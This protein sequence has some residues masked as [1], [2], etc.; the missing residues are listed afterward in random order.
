[1]YNGDTK[2]FNIEQPKDES[3]N[4]IIEIRDGE[5]V[6]TLEDEI[7]NNM[8]YEEPEVEEEQP[9]KKNKN[10]FKV[11]KNKWNDL[12]KKQK[13]IAIAIIAVVLIALIITLI[14]V[15]KK[16]E[17]VIEEPVVLEADNYRYENGKLY[18]LDKD[19]EDI[20]SY[21]CT[22]KKE[23]LCYVAYSSNE[24]NFDIEKNIYKDETDVQKRMSIIN[25]NYVFIYDNKNKNEDNIILYSIKENADYEAFKLVKEYNLEDDYIIAKNE[26][27]YYGVLLF[28]K[29]GYE[30]VIEFKYD[31][32]GVITENK[33][34]NKYLVG[35]K[36]NKWYLIDFKGVEKTKAYDNEIKNYSDSLLSIENA[37]EYYLYDFKG[38]L[39]TDESYDYINFYDEY[40]ILIKEEKL[41]IVDKD[42][43]KLYEEVIKVNMTSEDNYN[44]IN[45]FDKKTNK[46]VETKSSYKLEINNNTI[47]LFIKNGTEEVEKQINTFD[48]LVSKNY[49][50]INYFGG[51]LYFYSDE[52]KTELIGSY[53]CTNPNDITSENS[54]LSN[55]YIATN[56]EFSD[57]DMSYAKNQIGTLPI[58][59]NRFVF[60][61]D[62]PSLTSK[63]TMN[64]NLYDLKSNK[65]LGSYRAIDAGIYNGKNG[66]S[67]AETTGALIVA[68]NTKD[69]YGILKINLSEI[70][71]LENVKFS[72]K[73][74]NIEEINGN[75]IIQKATDTYYMINNQGEA[76]TSEF[77]GKIM[78]Y[79]NNYVK[80]KNGDNYSV[81]S[82]KGEEVSKNKFKYIELYDT[83]Y[84]GVDA[85]NKANI[86]TYVDDTAVFTE[87]IS[88]EITNNYREGKSFSA[89]INGASY[90]LT[91]N[92]TN[93]STTVYDSATVVNIVE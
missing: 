45:I 34:E 13:I 72:S 5:D 43:N 73:Y 84:V 51:I 30:E 15:L 74:K 79:K 23:T 40:V 66:V 19:G 68:K 69:Y 35:V 29:E 61:K 44:S 27:G 6:E 26:S 8:T 38:N 53:E 1:M 32:L 78:G 16:D 12:T 80:V 54:S 36:D 25:E 7:I 60:I 41:Y 88:L 92:N 4:E 11:I 46:L 63:E 28:N 2:E 24:D 71:S 10:I 48:S 47:N 83:F 55:C 39:K 49:P 75:Y 17:E 65:K 85:N 50:Y 76:L 70:V 37:S 18:F 33:K 64:I 57:N 87:N 56:S 93:G 81:F 3:V 14:F 77:S 22:N 59:N 31:Y 42:L 89:S 9:K 62:T 20:G 67:F 86:Y 82:Y 52:A 90:K 58:F 91:I 21:E